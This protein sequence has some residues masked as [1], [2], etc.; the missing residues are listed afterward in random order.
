MITLFAVMNG[1]EVADSFNEMTTAQPVMAQI[2]WY[3][4]IC[5]FI[6]VV[7]N[8]FIAII[9]AAHEVTE[10]Q[11]TNDFGGGVHESRRYVVPST[12]INADPLPDS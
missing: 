8:I 6:F 2:F 3:T 9:E 5:L 7:L 12:T 1:D 4:Y 10:V 11:H